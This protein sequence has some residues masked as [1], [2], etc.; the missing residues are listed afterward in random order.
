M[1][2]ARIFISYRRDDS[3]GYARAIGDALGREFGPAQVFVDVDDIG[4]GQPFGDV[5]RQAVGAS[6]TL[7]VLMGK[8]WAGPRDAGPLRITEPEDFVHQEVAAGLARGLRVVPLLLDGAAMPA[9]ADLPAPLRALAGRHA[10]ALDG[11]RFDADIQRLLAHLR[12]PSG[13]PAP[14]RRVWL[15]ATGTAAVLAALAGGT[16]WRRHR[17]EAAPATETPPSAALVGTWQAE[18]VYPWPNAR[19]QE[20]FEF[21]LDGSTLSGTASF[22]GVARRIDEGRVDGTSV[23]FSTRSST[24]QGE[25]RWED[26]HRYRGRLDAG[27]AGGELQLQMQTDS[28]GALRPPI[29]L[30]L[31]RVAGL[32]G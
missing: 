13:R 20:R 28:D 27:S 7:L 9:A 1:A 19:Y 12:P 5:I 4:A 31:R 2:G 32:G 21:T 30:R 15:L 6:D 22:L 25:R 18:A 11:A 14:R 10:L 16:L 26:V 24:E 8:R 29:A 3:A 17:G 23:S